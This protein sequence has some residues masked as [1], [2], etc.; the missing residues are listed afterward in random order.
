MPA[1]PGGDGGLRDGGDPG[2]W[3]AGADGGGVPC[4]LVDELGWA[5]D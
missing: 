4:A 1:A 5:A 2:A 3:E